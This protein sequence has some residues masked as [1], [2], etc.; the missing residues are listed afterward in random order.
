MIRPMASTGSGAQVQSCPN[1]GQPVETAGLEPFGKVNCPGCGFQLRVERV[2]ENYVVV[3]PLGTGGMG[4][5]YKARDTRLNRFVALKLLRKE[6]AGDAAFTAKLKD[7][8]RITASIR[9]PHV[10]EVYSVGE[11]HGQFYVVMELVDGGSL[12]DRIEDE[13]RISELET[14][15]VGLQVAKGLLA[16][17]QAGLIHRDIKPGNILFADRHTAKIVDF[18]LALLAAQ[19]AETE[20]EIWGTPYYIAPERLTNAKEDFRSDL[21]SLGATLFHAVSGRPTFDNETQSAAELKT[22]KSNPI[23]LKEVAARCLRRNRGRDR[24]NAASESGSSG[25][26]PTRS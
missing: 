26:I 21:Y 8:A 15:E 3:E 20:G 22:L 4:S 24:Q 7:E 10:V 1:C 25:R 12:D 6:F 17:L 9:H 5:V 13:K 19:H 2:F 16:A 14:L 18:G 23:G 11:D